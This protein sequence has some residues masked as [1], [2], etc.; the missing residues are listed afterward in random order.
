MWPPV[1]LVLFTKEVKTDRGPSQIDRDVQ[2]TSL[3]EF[4]EFWTL[5]HFHRC[6]FRRK[7]LQDN[8]IEYPPIRR[9]EDPAYLAEVL[10]KARSFKLMKDPTYLFH[11][12]HRTYEWTVEEIEHAYRGYELIQERMIAAGYE[13]IAFFFQC[14][15]SP[16]G[17]SYHW[18]PEEKALVLAERLISLMKPVPLSVL[19][20]SYLEHPVF[21]SAGCYHDLLL[22]KNA[23]PEQIVKWMRRGLFNANLHLQR[24]EMREMRKIIREQNGSLHRFRLWLRGPRFALRIIRFLLRKIIRL[25]N[26]IRREFNRRRSDRFRRWKERAGE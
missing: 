25:R 4:P 10:T 17:L 23:T 13:E 8:H 1:H 21:D 19:D 24:A 3:K 7:F 16:V 11:I 2:G 14:F 5:V 12:R 22:V 20:H 18:I 15:F 6:V 26:T 9:A